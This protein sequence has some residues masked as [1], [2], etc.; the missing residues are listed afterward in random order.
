MLGDLQS[1]NNALIGYTGFVG[2]NLLA[3]K[4]NFFTHLYNSKNIQEIRG[5]EFDDIYCAGVPAVKW[6]A[7]KHPEED[8]RSIASLQEALQKVQAKRFI[9]ISTIDVFPDPFQVNEDSA[10]S[11]VNHTYGKNRLLFE[12]FIKETFPQTYIFRLPGLFGKGLKKN[13]IYDL[14]NENN[15]EA[16]NP[17]HIFQFYNLDHLTTDIDVSLQQQLKLVHFATEPVQVAQIAQLF[18]RTLSEHPDQKPVHYDFYS[19]FSSDLK[20]KSGNY[21]YSQEEVLSEIA[22]FIKSYKHETSA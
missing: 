10:V 9:L 3:Q 12:N 21:L 20:N 7:N 14:L 22:D 19:K 1:M 11:S 16:I 18:E 4:E 15:V 13:I 6:Y 2:S 5:Q 17:Q 8:Q